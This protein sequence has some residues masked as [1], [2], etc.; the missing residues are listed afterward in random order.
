MKDL[1]S[2]DERVRLESLS[3]ARLVAPIEVLTRA[4]I[5]TYN[6]ADDKPRTLAAPSLWVAAQEAENAW[7][8]KQPA[9]VGTHA[10]PTPGAT[11]EPGRPRE[12][13]DE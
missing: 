5:E 1:E 4:L 6:D 9:A 10:S 11:H 3:Y 7:L 13:R 8:K 2:P 12:D